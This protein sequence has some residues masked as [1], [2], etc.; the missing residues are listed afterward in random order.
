[1]FDGAAGQVPASW[2]NIGD[3][4]LFSNGK[5]RIRFMAAPQARCSG[6][7]CSRGCCNPD[8]PQGG[9]DYSDQVISSVDTQVAILDSLDTYAN[10]DC[11]FF[12]TPVQS[13]AIGITVATGTTTPRRPPSVYYWKNDHTW[14]A[15]ADLTEARP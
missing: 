2:G 10:N 15:V 3:L 14:A 13:N 7:S 9:E 12:R 8:V 6:S 4:M 1:V 11:V 5:T